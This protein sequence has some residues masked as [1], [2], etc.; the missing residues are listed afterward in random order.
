MQPA[1]AIVSILVATLLAVAAAACGSTGPTPFHSYSNRALG[2]SIRYPASWSVIPVA[3]QFGEHTIAFGI[4][5]GFVNVT[6]NVF[7][8]GKARFEN[9]TSADL[10]GNLHVAETPV[11]GRVLH[12]GFLSIA[13]VRFAEVEYTQASMHILLL[14]TSVR[15]RRA[16]LL[17][18]R[19][20]CPTSQWS[21]QR[22][23]EM[24]ILA[25]LRTS[26]PRG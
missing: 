21:V 26:K 24:T 2:V 8:R 23:T 10:A 18:A 1:R 4:D 25:S 6:L 17:I 19:A 15:D 11:T 14:S 9:A 16:S 7:P 3:A 13:G 5:K 20:E 22:A 12:T